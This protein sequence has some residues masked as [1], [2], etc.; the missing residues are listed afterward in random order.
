MM[1][2]RLDGYELEKAKDGPLV[3]YED[4][5]KLE[6]KYMSAQALL[7]LYEIRREFGQK[8]WEQSE[9]DRNRLMDKCNILEK[10]IEETQKHWECCG[11]CAGFW[12]RAGDNGFCSWV[13]NYEPKISLYPGQTTF[14]QT[15]CKRMQS[16]RFTPSKWEMVK[17]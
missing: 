10:E 5:E 1:I 11:S 3:Y 8:A 15:P 17:N 2:E 13:E 12:P 16:C 4:Y 9:G 6:K 14:N 7:A